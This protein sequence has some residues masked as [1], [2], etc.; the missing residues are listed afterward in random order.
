MASHAF[1]HVAD[2]TGGMGGSGNDVRII[3]K[4]LRSVG[5]PIHEA[6]PLV[7]AIGR[8]FGISSNVDIGFR[9]GRSREP[10]VEG[11]FGGRTICFNCGLGGAKIELRSFSFA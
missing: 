10:N 3:V 7:E 8:N 2:G 5:E 4:G 9:F 6:L 1:D 11:D